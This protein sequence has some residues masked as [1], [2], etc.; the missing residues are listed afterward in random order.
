VID[1]DFLDELRRFDASL[2]RRADDLRQGEQESPNLGEGLTFADYR[3]YSPGDDIRLV[4]WRLYARTEEYYIKQFEEERNLTVHVLLDASGSM[5]FGGPDERGKFEFAAKLGLGFAY[6]TAEE[7]NDFRIATFA[8]EHERLDT[9]RS[10]RGEILRAIDLLNETEPA[11]E[12]SF[13][14]ALSGYESTI[15]SRSLVVVASDYLADPD[16]VEAGLGA[17][18]EN[19]LVCPQV[20]APEERE[21]GAEGDTIFVEP[22]TGAETRTYFGGSLKRTY[23]DRLEA[24]VETIG[25]RCRRLG[26]AHSLVATNKD[27]FDAFSQVWIG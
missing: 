15:G 18:A 7:N 13:E 25:E 14:R 17:L 26:A 1:P 27:F 23:R 5:G 6:L 19:D 8:D 2:D 4:D 11:G 24:H 20:I 10:N 21:P 9:G 22:E 3:R 16:D 12:A